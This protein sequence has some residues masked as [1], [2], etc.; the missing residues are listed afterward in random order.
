MKVKV[1]RADIKEGA[2]RAGKICGC[3]I[4]H[5]LGRKLKIAINPFEESQNALLVPHYEQ[6]RLGKIRIPLPK[7]AVAFQKKL[8]ADPQAKVRPFEFET[9]LLEPK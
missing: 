1:T 4:H 8:A 6:A 7:E 9:E 5:A 3:P 2:E